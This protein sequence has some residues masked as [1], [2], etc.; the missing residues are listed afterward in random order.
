MAPYASLLAAAVFLCAIAALFQRVRTSLPMPAPLGRP[1]DNPAAY[2]HIQTGDLLLF[3]AADGNAPIYSFISG[4][5]WTHA[6]IAIRRNGGIYIL[7]SP[8]S[9]ALTNVFDGERRGGVQL[10]NLE[11]YLD[12]TGSAVHRIRPAHASSVVLH[13]NDDGVRELSDIGRRRGY[14]MNPWRLLYAAAFPGFDWSSSSCA[15]T[16]DA[17][18]DR[19]WFCSA[20][21][22][23]MF[24]DDK[25]VDA[26]TFHPRDLLLLATAATASP[27]EEKKNQ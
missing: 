26:D 25:G 24:A 21:V 14:D 9:E 5:P 3:A 15:T 2:D 23:A 22:A 12:C 10:T 8:R 11:Y 1:Y 16:Q 13:D 27:S 17:T 6:G 20:F 19:A 4:A 18:S 7:H